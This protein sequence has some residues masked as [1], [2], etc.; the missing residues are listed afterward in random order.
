MTAQQGPLPLGT[1]GLLTTSGTIN[2]ILQALGLDCLAPSWDGWADDVISPVAISNSTNL[3][4]DGASWGDQTSRYPV[5]AKLSCTD[6]SVT[7]Y[8]YVKSAL[9]NGTPTFTTLFCIWALADGSATTLSGVPTNLRISYMA[10]PYGFPGSFAFT[11]ASIAYTGW[12]ATPTIKCYLSITGRSASLGYVIDGTGAGTART[13]TSPV[14][15]AVA[16]EE[17]V[18]EAFD[19][20]GRLSSPCQAAVSGST[21]TFYN[22]G[23]IWTNGNRSFVKGRISFPI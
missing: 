15:A 20:G 14:A 10:T 6:A 18:A 1:E 23:G 2:A 16:I 5:G 12:A 4:F 13:I 8:G 22:N 3:V 17:P 19:N 21:I 7:K 11:E 9:A